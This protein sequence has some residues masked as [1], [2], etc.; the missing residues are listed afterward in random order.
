MAEKTA[1]VGFPSESEITAN[2]KPAIPQTPAAKPSIP[3]RT[4]TMFISATT[5]TIVAP[6]PSHVGS[7]T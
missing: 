2:V 7:S 5:Q 3:S 6:T 4:L 1:A